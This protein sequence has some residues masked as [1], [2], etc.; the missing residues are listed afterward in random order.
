MDQFRRSVGQIFDLRSRNQNRQN[1]KKTFSSWGS[2]SLEYMHILESEISKIFLGASAAKDCQKKAGGCTSSRFLHKF[3]F[4]V[5]KHPKFWFR[6]GHCKDPKS[7]D[8]RDA[9]LPAET[10][11]STPPVVLIYYVGWTIKEALLVD[12]APL[13]QALGLSSQTTIPGFISLKQPWP[14]IT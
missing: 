1:L 5:P 13:Q 4:C 3:S 12:P 7:L 10:N 2:N 6:N 8:L 9:V 14:N 11:F